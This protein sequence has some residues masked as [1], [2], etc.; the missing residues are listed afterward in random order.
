MTGH[1]TPSAKWIELSDQTIEW[2][3]LAV[4]DYDPTTATYEQNT[5][6]KLACWAIHNVLSRSQG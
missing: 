1:I 3:E 5:P 2:I 6:E 4:K